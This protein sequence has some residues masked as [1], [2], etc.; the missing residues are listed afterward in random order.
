LLLVAGISPT[1]AAEGP[2]AVSV[3]DI[4]RASGAGDFEKSLR[5]SADLLA[6]TADADP[7]R[8][9]ALQ[10]RLDVI[11]DAD[12]WANQSAALHQAI[13]RLPEKTL[14]EAMQI[15]FATSEAAD[16]SNYSR[17]LE[18]ARKGL[19]KNLRVPATFA[20]EM[21][22]AAARALAPLGQ[23]E[24]AQSETLA[25]LEVWHRTAGVRACRYELGLNDM[26]A[27]I[28][29]LQGK[30][31]AALQRADSAMRVAEE[32][33]GR[34]SLAH[35][36]AGDQRAAAL[37]TM[38]RFA[39]ARELREATLKATREHFGDRHLST[40]LAEASLG[41]HLQTTGNYVPARDHYAVAEAI[42]RSLSNVGAHERLILA[43]NY[44]NLLQEMG[45]EDAALDHYRIALDLVADNRTRAII[46]TNI[47]NTEFRLHRFEAAIGDFDKA[48]PLREQAEGKDSPGLSFA[49]E[50]LGSSALA[51]RRF[52]D[53][54][55]YFTRAI[56][57][58]GRNSAPNHSQLNL[59]NFGLALSKWGQGDDD[60]AFRLAVQTATRQQSLIGS[61]ATGFSEQQSVAFDNL[62]MP[63]APLAV[64][65]A[66]A[67]GNAD[68][69]ATA[70]RLV[71]IERGLI[72]RAE[73]RR[74]AIARASADPRLAQLY[75]DWRT[76]N[77][78]L[79]DAWM[80]SRTSAAK[81]G[82]MQNAAEASERELWAKLGYRQDDLAAA[83]TSVDE[84][85]RALPKD[86]VL[87][88]FTEGVGSEPARVVNAG[89]AQPAE[90]LYAF[91]LHGGGKPALLRIGRIDAVA[92][93]THAWYGLLRNPHSDPE[94]L[95]QRGNDLRRDLLGAIKGLDANPSLF[96]VPAGELFRV[97]FAA[98][99]EPDG[100][101]YWIE[102]GMRVHTLSHES[103][104]MISAPPPGAVKALLAGAPQ[105]GIPD[106]DKAGKTAND[107]S[108]QMC[109][110]VA[111]HGFAPI[112][113]AARE[114]DELRVTLRDALGKAGDIVVLDG[115]QATRERVLAALDGAGI[116]HL[117]THGFSFDETCGA[118]DARG[119]TLDRAASQTAS[120]VQPLSGLAF[121]GADVGTGHAPV[122]VLSAGAISAADLSHADWVVLSACDSGLG[123]IGH[124]E[125]VFGMR[126]ALRLAGARTVV[127][128]LWEADDVAT[129]DLMQSLYRARFADHLDVPDA[130]ARAMR[131]T[132]AQ[133]RAAHLSTHPYFWGA[134]IGEG[135]WR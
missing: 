90:D 41:A 125:G 55:R 82:E 78:A 113:G 131:E 106:N 18:L 62:L 38:D 75:R 64:T 22:S 134:F 27:H 4:E 21:H 104:L 52:G 133:R 87:I 76:A 79:G 72:A 60:E 11:V 37:E 92:A 47:G 117:A 120:A 17:Q 105:F 124:A 89:A 115:A 34:N 71:M 33:F 127:M 30:T 103:E 48:L 108:R 59:L 94:R 57:L 129:A 49:L 132:I 5:L 70:W 36:L 123:P 116:V 32:V 3:D 50:G 109:A 46:L 73:A 61:L 69:I 16:A 110:R 10:A 99:P 128:S 91:V 77:S 24:A 95:R 74:L 19:E 98:L 66:A 6:H 9:A 101:G 43:N 102:S 96:V 67:H 81:M 56:A 118:G 100:K 15:S 84:L 107:M 14:R 7:Y 42:V 68:E 39:E 13:D 111:E 44:A 28:E 83:A 80:S 29:L 31:D 93:Q 1:Q 119:M 114:L 121:A 63:A 45:D 65:I 23:L 25:A 86:G 54:E 126:R 35:A 88:A 8:I 12:E 135:G 2:V 122:G 40:A 51:L 53:A 97:S 58:R 112:P 85:A 20:A 130:M 26:L